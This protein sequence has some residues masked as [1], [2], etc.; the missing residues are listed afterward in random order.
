[1]MAIG[2]QFVL[3]QFSPPVATPKGLPAMVWLLAAENRF[4][5]AGEY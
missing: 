2:A 3:V 4:V 5:P 1:M